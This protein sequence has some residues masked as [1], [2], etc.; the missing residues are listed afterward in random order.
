MI[1]A[2]HAGNL[3]AEVNTAGHEGPGAYV[4]ALHAEGASLYF[5]RGGTGLGTF[6]I[7]RALVTTDGETLGPAVPVSE[8]NHPTA[9]DDDPAISHDGKEVFFWRAAPAA[10]LWTATRK[11]PHGAWSAPELVGGEIDTRGGDQTVGLSHDGRTLVW[12]TSMAAR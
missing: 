11:N 4:P 12:S 1:L 6:D 7:Y 2:G 10:G 8:L 5:T 9:L 3:G